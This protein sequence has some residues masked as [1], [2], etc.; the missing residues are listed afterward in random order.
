MKIG[1]MLVL[2]AAAITLTVGVSTAT[3][4]PAC[5]TVTTDTTLSSDCSG[6]LT[7]GASGI[8]VDL[9]GHS[10]LCSGVPGVTGVDVGGSSDIVVE[11]GSVDGCEEGVL[12]DGG[13]SNQFRALTLTNNN[14]GF[15][16]SN[17]ASTTIMRNQVTSSPFTG[18]LLFQ[19]SGF[20][21]QRNTVLDSGIGIFD[22]G[23]THNVISLNT[24][25]RGVGISDIGILLNAK[26]DTVVHNSTV[27]N[28]TGI[29]VSVPS[30]P[31]AGNRL[32]ANTS[33][34]NT[35]LDMRDDAPGCDSNVWK[36]NT[37]ITANQ[38][39]IN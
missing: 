37:F 29:W 16:V 23:G 5:G 11:N 39:C 38:P 6:P 13:N 32:L 12:A 17:S 7:V 4:A 21:V 9:A 18:V 36:A 19:T 22:N 24:A 28:A 1:M 33:T 27:A 3:D 26:S 14:V 8:T 20:L 34:G 31:Q 25:S 35:V 2:C 30:V 10:V 15:E